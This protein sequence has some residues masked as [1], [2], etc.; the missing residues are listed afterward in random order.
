MYRKRAITH[1]LSLALP[2]AALGVFH[3]IPR[4]P[5]KLAAS[6][7]LAYMFYPGAGICADDNEAHII[8]NGEDNVGAIVQTGDFN[9]V[10]LVQNPILQVGRYNQ[11]EISQ[12]GF[13]NKVGKNPAFF[14]SSSAGVTQTGDSATPLIFN[15]ISIEQKSNDNTINYIS[16][17]AVG[18]IP[19]GANRLYVVQGNGAAGRNNLINFVIQK[20]NVGM[21]GQVARIEQ[22]GENNVIDR[23][24]QKSLTAAAFEENI[25]RVKITGDSNGIADLTGAALASRSEFNSFIQSIGYD[26]LGANGNFADFLI[27]GNSNRFGVFQGGRKNSIGL[28]SISATGESNQI[29]LRQ[30]GLEND[31]TMSVLEGSDNNVGVGQIGTNRASLDLIGIDSV[32]NSLLGLQEGTNDL[33]FTVQG[34]ENIARADQGYHSGM[35]GDNLASF[36]LEGDNNLFNLSQRGTASFKVVVKGD[37][38]NTFAPT[39]FTA[40]SNPLPM[41]AGEFLQEGMNNFADLGITG[42]RNAIGTWQKGSGNR[43]SSTTSGNLNQAA[44]VQAGIN[45]R[46]YLNQSGNDNTAVFMQ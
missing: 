10:G 44:F 1:T 30:D 33:F 25:I 5:T 24:E 46:A 37:Q 43:I 23:V 3:S 11:L 40:I 28:V 21:P 2:S 12:T 7:T 36:R 39:L 6:I 4:L 29:G 31:I 14:G 41:A 16:Q 26:N 17:E 15:E 9:E 18:A 22:A 13:R 38:T 45:N 8:Q 19:E 27:E 35:G 32:G 34:S 20:Q 42:D